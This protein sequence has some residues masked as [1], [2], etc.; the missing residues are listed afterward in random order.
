MSI[1]I[2]GSTDIG[3]KTSTDGLLF[4]IDAGNPSSYNGGS[5]IYDLSSYTHDTIKFGSVNYESSSF[6]TSGN[7]GS[8]I[9]FDVPELLDTNLATFEF[10]IKPNSLGQLFNTILG[11]DVYCILAVTNNPSAAPL[12]FNTGNGDYNYAMDPLNPT[13][14]F[15]LQLDQWYHIVAL[16]YDYHT[17]LRN[18]NKFWVNGIDMPMQYAPTYDPNNPNPQP[19]TSVTSQQN[20]SPQGKGRISSIYTP[21]N[22]YNYNIGGY[23][24]IFKIYNRILSQEEITANYNYYK[25]RYP[26]L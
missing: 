3:Y 5:P 10:V 13:Q 19:G 24:P 23:F 6:V 7:A 25:T 12:S 17:P 4:Y 26:L 18:H 14:P 11:F 9:P 8:L 21:Y 2:S 16:M 20:F 22:S 1:I 15:Y